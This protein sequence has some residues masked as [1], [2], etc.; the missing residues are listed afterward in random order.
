KTT[1]RT[2][3]NRG[4]WGFA[5]NEETVVRHNVT[6]VSYSRRFTHQYDA[7]DYDN[8]TNCTPT[9]PTH[10]TPAS[11][12]VTAFELRRFQREHSIIHEHGVIEFDANEINTTNGQIVYD[13]NKKGVIIRRPGVYY[14]SYWINIDGTSDVTGTSVAFTDYERQNMIVT[15]SPP[16]ATMQIYGCGFIEIDHREVP[17]VMQL[18]NMSDGSIQL[19]A[20]GQYEATLS[21]MHI[22]SETKCRK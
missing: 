6:N 14:V 12:T 8:T 16:V 2:H 17:R 9:A 15:D 5:N 21:I 7:S 3:Q 11:H 13:P 19:G 4:T 20:A 22:S 10:H 18:I 1:Q